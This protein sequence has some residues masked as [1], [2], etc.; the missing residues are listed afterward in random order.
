[1]IFFVRLSLVLFTVG[2]LI[3]VFAFGFDGKRWRRAAMDHESPVGQI[4]QPSAPNAAPAAQPEVNKATNPSFTPLPAGEQP[5][6]R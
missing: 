6:S 2:V 5:A 4:M 1:M 3:M